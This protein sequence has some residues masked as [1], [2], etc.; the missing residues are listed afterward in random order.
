[1][2]RLSLLTLLL[3]AALAPAAH[4]RPTYCSKAAV[5]EIRIASSKPELAGINTVICRDVTDDG[6][7]DAIYTVLSGGTAGPVRFGVIRG[8]SKVTILREWEGYKVTVDRV[9]DHRFDVQQPY[10]AADDPN[11]CPSA[12][13]VTPYR[14]KR[15]AFKAGRTKR[16]EDFQKRF[17]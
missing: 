3:A 9:N 1:M 13:D 10:Y 7:R 15:R 17:K 5:Q 14:F 11:C 12:F 2:V 6:V 16:Y 8:G 4:A